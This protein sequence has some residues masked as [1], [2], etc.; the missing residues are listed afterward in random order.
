LPFDINVPS[1]Q[2]NKALDEVR[3]GDGTYHDDLDGLMSDLKK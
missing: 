1:K 2:L 3:D